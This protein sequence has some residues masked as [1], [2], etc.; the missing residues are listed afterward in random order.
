MASAF[1]NEALQVQKWCYFWYFFLCFF[2]FCL[3]T[4][5]TTPGY[6]RLAQEKKKKSIA[7]ATFLP[8]HIFNSLNQPSGAR[9]NTS[10]PRLQWTLQRL[11]GCGVL[12][13][14]RLTFR[15]ANPL[16]CSERGMYS[17]RGRLE[18]EETMSSPWYSIAP[19]AHNNTFSCSCEYAMVDCDALQLETKQVSYKLRINSH[20]FGFCCRVLCFH[21]GLVGL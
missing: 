5:S 16:F 1:W 18:S 21:A 17:M 19:L 11:G 12:L 7:S 14:S 6:L 3:K 15:C 20:Y 10:T 8:F 4:T 2:S 9:T 13:L